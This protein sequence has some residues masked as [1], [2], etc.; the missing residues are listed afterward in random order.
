MVSRTLSG[1]SEADGKEE[2]TPGGN[3]FLVCL[4]V[5]GF[6]RLGPKN[7]HAGPG[8]GEFKGPKFLCDGMR[9]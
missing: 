5:F 3:P 2:K 9:G 6:F 7:G 1:G 8:W 4:P